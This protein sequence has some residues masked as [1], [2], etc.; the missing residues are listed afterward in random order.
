MEAELQRDHTSSLGLQGSCSLSLSSLH[1]TITKEIFPEGFTVFINCLAFDERGHFKTGIASGF[2][3]DHA[4]RVE[5]LTRTQL[6]FV[7]GCRRNILSA[8]ESKIA[9]N[10]S[11]IRDKDY[12]ACLQCEDDPNE[13]CK[14][15]KDYSSATLGRSLSSSSP[16]TQLILDK[17]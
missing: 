4:G 6:R 7:I 5:N 1:L 13:A 8:I 17:L 15:R 14:T 9:A 11:D 2:D 3:H 16:L 12:S 10:M